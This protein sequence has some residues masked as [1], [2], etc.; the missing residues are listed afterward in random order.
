MKEDQKVWENI[1]KEIKPEDIMENIKTPALF[2]K[3]LCNYIESRKTGPVKIVEMGCETAVCSILLNDRFEKTLLDYTESAL[4]LVREVLKNLNKEAKLL[5]EDMFNTSISNEEYDIVFNAGVVEHYDSEEITS[6]LKEYSRILKNDGLIIIAYPNHYSYP[7]RFAYLFR[8]L[9]GKW[10]Y[11][12]E[13]KI[14]DLSKEAK[15]AGLTQ[16][17]RVVIS[18]G[19]VLRWV[20]FIPGAQLFFRF[21]AKVLDYEGY[22]T[23][24]TL[25]KAN[26]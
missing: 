21:L 26:H 9:L 18:K 16:E 23:V 4:D 8:N 2:Q 20:D 14:Y 12:K 22:L 7:Y 15:E 11:P 13:N 17:G 25:K 19:S 1:I 6:A 3:E 5:N 10:K 24:I